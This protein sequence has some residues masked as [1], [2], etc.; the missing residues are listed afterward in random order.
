MACIMHTNYVTITGMHSHNG[1]WISLSCFLKA[2]QRRCNITTFHLHFSKKYL[3]IPKSNQ[4]NEN[5]KYCNNF[6]GILKRTVLILVLV[7]DGDKMGCVADEIKIL[8]VSE[9]SEIKPNS[10]WCHN[11]QI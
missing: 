2:T 10:M 8:S 4:Q 3:H 5:L 7:L 1:I 9:P 11:I 6:V